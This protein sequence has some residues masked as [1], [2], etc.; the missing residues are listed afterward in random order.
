LHPVSPIFTL[1]T[2]F[3]GH[4]FCTS[5]AFYLA[6][7]LFRL[8]RLCHPLLS[9]SLSSYTWVGGYRDCKRVGTGP[10]SNFGSSLKQMGNYDLC[11]YVI[12]KQTDKRLYVWCWY[13]N[14]SLRG[15][16]LR[17]TVASPYI[18][19]RKKIIC[20]KLCKLLGSWDWASQVVVWKE[21]KSHV[22]ENFSVKQCILNWFCF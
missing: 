5:S 9:L 6:I 18:Y 17:C 8:Q 19:L 22:R 4:L 10:V 13:K 14:M 11:A 2:S 7:F 12:W 20:E 15:T 3:F 21:R 16:L 1:R